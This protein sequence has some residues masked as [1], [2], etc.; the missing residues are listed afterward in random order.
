MGYKLKTTKEDLYNKGFR[1]NSI[2]SDMETDCYSIRFPVLKYNK[3]TTLECELTVELQTG[4]VIINVFNYR[5]RDQY[6]PYYYVEYGI[7]DTLKQIQKEINKY[8]NKLGIKEVN[9]ETID[10]E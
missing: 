9:S 4:N 8:I 1:Y 3:N 2:A 5:T 6:T 7:Y 10:N